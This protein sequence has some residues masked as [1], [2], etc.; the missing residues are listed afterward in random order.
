MIIDASAAIAILKQEPEA[1]AC[2]RAIEF[3][4]IRKMAAPTYLE[5]CM[6]IAGRG[7]GE[8]LARVDEFMRASQIIS[9][10]FTPDLALV[11]VDAFMRYGKGRHPARL[12]FGDCIA[13]ALA[14]SEAMPL[15]FKGDDF[16]LTDIQPAI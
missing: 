3:A 5:I 14:K 4:L 1:A 8:A 9:M 2:S 12:N 7:G 6:V 11:A 10:S 13:Y 15:L 16:R